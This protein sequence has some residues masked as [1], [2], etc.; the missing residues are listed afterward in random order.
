MGLLGNIWGG[1]TAVGNAVG[2]A[3]SSAASVVANNPIKTAL[4]AF[5]PTGVIMAGAQVAK[6]AVYAAKNPV[7]A[8]TNIIR[9]RDLIGQGVTNGV[10]STVGGIAD[11]GRWGARRVV[12]LTSH[13]MPWE[14]WEAP[15]GGYEGVAAAWKRQTTFITP[16]NNYERAILYGTQAVFEVGTFVAVSVGTA[17]A[18]GAALAALRVGSTT[19]KIAQTG[20]K[21]STLSRAWQGSKDGVNFGLKMSRPYTMRSQR[22]AEATQL[23]SA[24]FA[25]AAHNTTKLKTAS[26]LRQSWLKFHNN[27]LI[28]T[29]N[30]RFGS[31]TKPGIAQASQTV[32]DKFSAGAA[33]Y[34]SLHTGAH[35]GALK[36]VWYR[37]S[38]IERGGR[39]AGWA[40]GLEAGGATMS[41]SMNFIGSVSEKNRQN[42]TGQ[43]MDKS[44]MQQMRDA[45]GASSPNDENHSSIDSPFQT[46]SALPAPAMPTS[47]HAAYFTLASQIVEAREAR[48]HMA[49]ADTDFSGSTPTTRV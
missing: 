20:Q 8:Y 31:G 13:V 12:N 4:W 29:R 34:Q 15:E 44:A 19:A 26:G 46:A 14:K 23:A 40:G 48:I 7:K 39:V 1:V 35:N 24:R 5:P 22:A 45:A 16:R 41:L 47:D 27:R 42:E 30:A 36:T 38:V 9:T 18:G 37:N 33:A 28:G 2:G 10:T 43:A 49:S 25:V 21:A 17:G 32:S 3:V 6:G 11:L